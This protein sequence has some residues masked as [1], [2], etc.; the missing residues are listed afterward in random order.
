[1][2][3][4]LRIVGSHRFANYHEPFLGGASIFLGLW[5]DGKSYLRDL[6]S[7]LIET[8][9]VIARDPDGVADR[10]LAH[11]NT[12]EHYYAT[13][14]AAPIDATDRAARFVYLNHT[15]FNGIHRVNLNGVYNVPYGRRP[16]T[17]IPDR[18]H[19]SQFARRL[20]SAVL[21]SGDFEEALADIGPRDL[22]FLDPPY[23]VAHNNNG[24]VRYNQRLFSFEDQH[25]LSRLVDA[26]KERD[27]FYVLTNAAHE[28]IAELFD[29]GDRRMPTSRKN[30]VGG[31]SAIRGTATEY[32][33]TN[34]PSDA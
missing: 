15:S 17:N 1:M 16:S 26:I 22:V 8:Y 13:R 11:R 9:E 14:S 5:P 27:A 21:A 3:C 31:N 29:K 4:L 33:F 25:R 32:L 23:T 28:S 34:V 7:E 24:F 6:N 30:A 20:G 19:L 10:L 12:E 18:A 2:P